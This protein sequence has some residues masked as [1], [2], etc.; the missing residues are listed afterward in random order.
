LLR[1][2]CIDRPVCPQI[3][4]PQ[5]TNAIAPKGFND[6]SA[7]TISAR[8]KRESDKTMKEKI[9][10]LQK[11]SQGDMAPPTELELSLTNRCNQNCLSC[12]RYGEDLDYEQEATDAAF[13][14]LIE[15]ASAL[16]VEE[17]H[18]VGGGELLVRDVTPKVMEKAKKAGMKGDLVTNGTL[19]GEHAERIVDMGW[20]RIKVSIDGPNSEIHD[21]LRGRDGAFAESTSS[22]RKVQG[23]KQELGRE[24]PRLLFNTVVSKKNYQH[25]LEIYQLANRLGIDEVLVLPLTIFTEK[26]EELKLTE[27]ERREF[28]KII[29]E[30]LAYAEKKSIATNLDE[31]LEEK[32]LKD[33]EEMDKVQEEEAEAGR[34]ALERLE[35]NDFYSLPC[36]NPWFHVTVNAKGQIGTCF[37]T[38]TGKEKFNIQNKSLKDN[39]R[40]GYFQQMRHNMLER[41]L[42]EECAQCCVWKVFENKELRQK[43]RADK[44]EGLERLLNKISD[45]KRKIR[46]F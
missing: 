16:G 33:T 25:F 18:L 4:H 46:R 31:F 32:Y 22:I 30:V 11:W 9:K 40:G 36:Y 20:D 23:L 17:L 34:E 35:E 21:Y 29:P 10:R 42:P 37:N 5:L 44:P 19:L 1:G 38:V 8:L 45:I 14:N 15:D 2:R 41:N 6:S 28:Q 43:L 24:K 13:L 39:W 26:G 7:Q 27:E 3:E 12:W